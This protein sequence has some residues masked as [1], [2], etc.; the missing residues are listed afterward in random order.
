ML[1]NSVEFLLFFPAVV[2]LYFSISYKYRWIILT[3]ASYYFY[4]C[5]KAEYIL[6]IIASTL[7]NYYSGLAIEKSNPKKLKKTILIINLIINLGTLFAF[8]YL[9]FFSA[10]VQKVLNLFN[11]FYNNPSLNILLPVG[12]SFYTFIALSYIIDVY[13]GVRKAENHIGYFASYLSFFPQILAGPIARSTSLLP[14]FFEKHDF[15]SQRVSDGLKLML[16][17]FFKKIVIADRLAILVN[18]VYGNPQNHEGFTLLIATYFF[19]FQI[20]CD[21]SGYSDIAIGAAQVLGFRLMENFKRPYHATSISDFWNRWHISL[22]TWLRD[23]LFLPLA[24]YFTRKMPKKEYLNLKTDKLTYT[25]SALI[26]FLLCGLWHGANWTFVV[27]GVIHGFYL[28]FAVWTKKI[29]N[30]VYLFFKLKKGSTFRNLVDVFITFHLVLFAWIFFKANS[31]SDALYIIT[32]IFPLNLNDFIAI[33]NSTG[34]TE[35]VFGLTKRGLLLAI[36]S[37]VLMEVVHLM[38]LKG[39]VRNMLSRKPLIIRWAVY[40]LLIISI[41]SFGEFNMQEFIYFQF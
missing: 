25:F 9:N 1:F 11:I 19:A 16:W 36:I 38:Q 13:R 10:S 29:T 5:W 30:K 27:W 23:Y 3:A 18:Q 26:T 14:Q 7:I 21:F 8:K 31:L 39:S 33:L 15:D 34:A 41:I 4:M 40:Y 28:I 20:Y 35:A 37:I 12:I 17:G 22:S 32:H 24:Y 6:L 2:I